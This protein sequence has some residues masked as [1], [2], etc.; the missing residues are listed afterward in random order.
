MMTGSK[1]VKYAA[2]NADIR[3]VYNLYL[4]MS[5]MKICAGFLCRPLVLF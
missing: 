5:C 3:N 1:A 4:N 2:T